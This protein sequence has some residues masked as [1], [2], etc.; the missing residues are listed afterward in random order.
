MKLHAISIFVVLF[1]CGDFELHAGP[2]GVLRQEVRDSDKATSAIDFAVLA[3]SNRHKIQLNLGVVQQDKES[4]SFAK[5]NI[6]GIAEKKNWGKAD[7]H[8]AMSCT[9]VQL[10][11]DPKNDRERPLDPRDFMRLL[12]MQHFVRI[13]SNVEKAEV[14][15]DKIA[16]EPTEAKGYLAEGEYRV[17]VSKK[18]YKDGEKT[19]TVQASKENVFVIELAEDN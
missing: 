3:L 14:T 13:G 6:D 9:Y 15:V 2:L 17:R 19:I 12:S 16:W 11:F 1:V 18:G 8:E 4:I 5:Q 10:R 7:L